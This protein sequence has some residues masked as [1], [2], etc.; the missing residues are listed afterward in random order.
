MVIDIDENDADE[1]VSALTDLQSHIGI[2][3]D[4]IV[5][6]VN[7]QSF[8]G[9]KIKILEAVNRIAKECDIPQYQWDVN[10]ATGQRRRLKPYQ[11]SGEPAL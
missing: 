2:Q 1:I 11:V 10:I 4:V 5:N 7:R 9:S 3:L 8:G 6:E